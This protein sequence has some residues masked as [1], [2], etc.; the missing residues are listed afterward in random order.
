MIKNIV[1]CGFMGS[2]KT[3]TGKLLAKSLG[4]AFV[5]MDEYIEK[6]NGMTV[7][8]IF[9]K[10]GEAEFRRMETEAARLLGKG[11]GTVI[12]CGGGAVLRPENVTF[13]KANGDLFYLSVTADTVK[14]RLKNDTTRPLLKDDKANAIITLLNSREPIYLS[15]ADHIIDSNGTKESAAE[16]ITQI[17]KLNK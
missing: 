15:V 16:Q 14:S 10:Y 2:G 13:L 12:A 6:S 7:N 3:V 5:D 17:Y 9:A 11:E 4:L 1:L 8:E